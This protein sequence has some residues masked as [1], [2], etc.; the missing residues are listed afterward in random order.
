MG[1]LRNYLRLDTSFDVLFRDLSKARG[2]ECYAQVID[3]SSGGVKLFTD[4]KL[5]K[6]AELQLS[7]L[8]RVDRKNDPG[9]IA[10]GK[11]VWQREMKVAGRGLGR[12]ELGIHFLSIDAQERDQIFKHIYRR[13]AAQ[14][15]VRTLARRC[16]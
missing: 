11:V 13:L 10:T 2:K 9:I 3:A 14:K 12:Y 5:E 8:I 4:Q 6:G 1:D 16:I 15:R 7:F